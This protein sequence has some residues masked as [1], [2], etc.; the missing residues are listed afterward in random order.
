MRKSALAIAVLSCM[1]ASALAAGNP[2]VA[3]NIPIPGVPETPVVPKTPHILPAGQYPALPDEV[4]LAQVRMFEAVPAEIEPYFDL[5]LYV[6]KAREGALAQRMY[7]FERGFD[8]MVYP[9]A[10]WLVSTGRERREKYFTTTPVGLYKFDRDRLFE[11]WWS[12]RWQ[13]AMPYTMFLDFVVG[14][15]KAGIA[16]HGTTPNHFAELGTRASGGCIRLHP[17]HAQA[18]LR[19]M[20]GGAFDGMV[21]VFAW[22]NIGNRTDRKGAVVY[23]KSGAILLQKGLKVLL[24]VEDF[25]G[26]PAPLLAP[27]IA[28]NGAG[29]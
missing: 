29:Q 14:Q 19:L 27:V 24:Y 17:E 26:G 11:Y 4:Q 6:S 9:I 7:V 3:E 1:S 21:P 5:F 18:L 15:G 13:A 10:Q 23:D 8:R 12:R 20:K 25:D 22:D 2:A 28:M 16:V